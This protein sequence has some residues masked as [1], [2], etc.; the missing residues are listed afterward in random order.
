[1][2]PQPPLYVIYSQPPLPAVFLGLSFVFGLLWG[3]F[4][5]VCIYRL[6]MGLSPNRP[7]RSF[8]F[9]CGTPIAWYDNIPLLSWLILGGRCRQ[10]GARI[11]FRY[12]AI[13]FITGLIFALL[14]WNVNRPELVLDRGGF[15]LAI[16][17]YWT[18]AGFLIIGAMTDIDHWIIPDVITRGGLW[19]ALAVALILPLFARDTLIARTGPFPMIRQV[20]TSDPFQ[21]IGALLGISPDRTSTSKVWKPV[22]PPAKGSTGPPLPFRWYEPFLNA[23]CGAVAGYGLLWGIAFIG[24]LVFRREAMGGGDLK[25]FAFLGAVFGPFLVLILLFLSSLVGVVLGVATMI[26]S[27]IRPPQTVRIP[28][29]LGLLEPTPAEEGA[30][31]ASSAEPAQPG[32]IPG[33]SKPKAAGPPLP[34]ADGPSSASEE[35]GVP[36]KAPHG[37]GADAA[38]RRTLDEYLVYAAKRPPARTVHH[39]PFGPSISLAA[40]VLLIF[41]EPIRTF[42]AGYLLPVFGG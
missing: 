7:R 6:P 12:F 4:F 13:E 35:N 21:T 17:W 23:V 32:Y 14:W 39:L 34:P 42:L 31:A 30:P 41:H 40:L 27:A 24:R 2:D 29:L 38:R 28:D 20:D 1:M 22:R 11:S 36:H 25:L 33:Y 19:T 16:V 26:W 5:N 3:S 15:S 8:C 9:S 10:C 18:V 37:E